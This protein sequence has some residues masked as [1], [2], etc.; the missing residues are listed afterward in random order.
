MHSFDDLAPTKHKK[1][2]ELK[3]SKK[4]SLR[5]LTSMLNNE[6]SGSSESWI[7]GRT[8][9]SEQYIL[10]LP[11]KH[12]K[13]EKNLSSQLVETLII[14]Q[15]SG[16]SLPFSKP[17][18]SSQTQAISVWKRSKDRFMIKSSSES[19]LTKNIVPAVTASKRNLITEKDDKENDMNQFMSKKAFLAQVGDE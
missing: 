10:P 2:A 19:H 9:F 17:V 12:Q 14:K 16:N 4:E 6:L 5:Q 13:P 11:N 1:L 8:P 3:V 15:N 18:N 7:R